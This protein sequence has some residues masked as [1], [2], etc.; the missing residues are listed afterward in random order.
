MAEVSN[1]IE[2]YNG[3]VRLIREDEQMALL[4][5]EFFQKLEEHELSNIFNYIDTSIHKDSKT[6]LSNL[7]IKILGNLIDNWPTIV[8]SIEN[9]KVYRL[10]QSSDIFRTYHSSFISN[11]CISASNDQLFPFWINPVIDENKDKKRVLTIN[12][13]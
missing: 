10:I 12:N 4:A 1:F 13:Q 2:E 6:K 11:S 8:S 3:Y 5:H 9:S 7:E